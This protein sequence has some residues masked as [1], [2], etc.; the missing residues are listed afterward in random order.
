MRW[1]IVVAVLTCSFALAQ[2]P[3][4]L[5]VDIRIP[6][7]PVPFPS[8]GKLYYAYELDVS[9]FDRRGRTL[10]LSSVEVLS[11][12]AK[13]LA[14]F[15]SDDLKQNLM[16]PG[17]AAGVDSRQLGAGRHAVLFLW[18][19]VGENDPRPAILRH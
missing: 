15:G 2:S 12:R 14:K 13:T 7:S 6:V 5:P 10:T 19:A 8:K 1:S 17:I 9:N 18:V 16:Q 11:D 4:A 3:S